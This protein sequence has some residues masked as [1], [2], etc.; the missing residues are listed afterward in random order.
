MATVVAAGFT[1]FEIASRL[2]VYANAPQSSSA[3]KFGTQ[4]I[5][6]RAFRARDDDEWSRELQMLNCAV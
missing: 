6:F 4:G 5:N 3:A 1:R 2:D